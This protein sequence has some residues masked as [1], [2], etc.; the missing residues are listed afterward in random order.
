MERDDI[1]DAAHEVRDAV[2]SLDETLDCCL[3][4]L[5][6]P[7]AALPD[8]RTYLAGIVLGEFLRSATREKVLPLIEHEPAGIELSQNI[9]NIV[10]TFLDADPYQPQPNSKE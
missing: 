6:H 10:E 4:R 5:K 2:Q 3:E 9:W 8:R 7:L 1:M